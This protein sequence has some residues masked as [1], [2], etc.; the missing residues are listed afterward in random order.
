MAQNQLNPD[1]PEYLKKLASAAN[2]RK[3]LINPA[4]E[5]FGFFAGGL[6]LTYKYSAKDSFWEAAK[7]IYKQASPAKTQEKV[8]VGIELKL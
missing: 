8:L 4:G 3:F 5:Q 7:K 2:L 1:A 6:E